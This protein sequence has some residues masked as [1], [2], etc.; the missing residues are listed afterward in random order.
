MSDI[1]IKTKFSEIQNKTNKFILGNYTRNEIAFEYGVGEYLFDTEG[2][3]YIDFQSGIAVTN[4]GHSE[5][6]IID[7]LREQADKLF[8]TS[9]LFYSAEQADLAET[10]IVHSFPGKVFFCNSGT[11][12]NEAAMKLARKHAVQKGIT[13]PVIISLKGSFHGRTSGSMSMTGQNKIREGF[14]ELVPGFVFVKENSIEELEQA[15][16]QWKGK[17]AGFIAE[18]ILGEYG[19]LPIKEDFLKRARELTAENGCP[20]IL[21]EIQT[22]IG[23]TGKLFCFQHYKFTPDIVTLA[24][25]LGS[26]FPIGAVIIGEKFSNVLSPGSHGSTFGGNHL[27]A[28]VAFETIR[29]L[30]TR[31]ILT[32]IPA[33][34]DF[35]FKRLRIVQQKFPKHIKEIRGIGLHIGV[36]L[37]SS[38][39]PIVKKCLE[40]GLILNSTNETVIRIMP[41]LQ[42]SIERIDEAMTILE[43]VLGESVE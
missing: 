41:P 28:R 39:K 25:G 34:S 15:F 6:D 23:R 32:N 26:G 30:M 37:F 16:S 11:E 36:E 42:I 12:A 27:A 3:Q 18:P 43:K 9:N 8:H 5:A 13:D 31:D 4:L 29:V 33:L 38:S 17:I 35:F 22:G 10:L 7:A 1:S 40:Y 21:D 14:G 2:K 20:M 24:K 19:V